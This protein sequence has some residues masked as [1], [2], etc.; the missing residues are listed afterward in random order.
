[1]KPQ[2]KPG[3]FSLQVA[4]DSRRGE[5]DCK[6]QVVLEKEIPVHTVF[7]GDSI[8]QMWEL[9]AYFSRPGQVYLNRGIGGDV[10]TYIRSR[11]AADVVQLKPRCC[12]LMAGVND[13]W[14]L[15]FNHWR[16]EPGLSVETILSTAAENHTAI[17]EMAVQNGIH[18]FLCSVLPTNMLWTNHEPERREYILRLNEHLRSLGR[19][20][21]ITYVD[22]Y[23][24]M[25]QPDAPLVRDG[26]TIEGLHPNVTGYDIMAWVLL[27]SCEREGYSL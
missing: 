2:V 22:Y 6:N 8:T 20:S 5:F 27:D 12:V 21:A 10:T 16:Q 19:R 26:L 17:A 7:I 4:A 18:L 11:F 13:A 14:D 23:T 1:M 9:A 15:E 25:V 3:Y 24:H